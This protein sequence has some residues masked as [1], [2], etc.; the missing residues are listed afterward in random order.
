[1][2]LKKSFLKM[3][4]LDGSGYVTSCLGHRHS[5][6]EAKVKDGFMLLSKFYQILPST[7]IF[8]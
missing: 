5:P 6:D 3:V 1:M 4:R 7:E 8:P 2:P